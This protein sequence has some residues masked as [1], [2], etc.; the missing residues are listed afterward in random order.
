MTVTLD[1]IVAARR[2]IA[3]GV[4]RTP[5]TEAPGLSALVGA[6]VFCKLEYKQRTGS[7]KERGARNALELLDP[8]ARGRGV[9]AASAGNHALALAWHGRDLGIPVTVVMPRTAPIVK[10]TRCAGYGARVELAGANIGE[11]KERADE[12]VLS[13][14]LTYVH[15]FDGADIIAGQGTI[16]LELLEEIDDLDAVVVPVGGGGL[17][18]G[19]AV[20]IKALRPVVEIIGVEPARAASFSAAAVA[21]AP[22]RIEMQ[23]TLADGLA[24]PE[25]GGRAFELAHGLVD[26]LHT[27]D[28][29]SISLAIRRLAELHRGV[30]GGGGAATRAAF[31]AG[32]RERV[33][34]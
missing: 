24:V 22:V 8:D 7:F 23:P 12:L 30:G 18:A 33:R 11:A 31:V 6:R 15:G 29:E 27:V 21:G 2:R 17:L 32:R 3:G 10:Q 5:C 25:V 26:E 1:T 14:G 9:V 13:N 4:F 34:G 16:G 28:E 19:V 20:A